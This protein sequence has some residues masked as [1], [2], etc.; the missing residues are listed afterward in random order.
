MG[1][2]R[3]EEEAEDSAWIL[4]FIPL[5]ADPDSSGTDCSEVEVLGGGVETFFSSRL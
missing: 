5:D 1:E 3:A 4:S 2:L